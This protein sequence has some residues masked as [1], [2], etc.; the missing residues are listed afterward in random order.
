VGASSTCTSQRVQVT[1]LTRDRLLLF[2][3]SGLR[4]R[5]HTPRWRRRNVFGLRRCFAY[6]CSR[7]APPDHIPYTRTHPRTKPKNVTSSEEL[8]HA[9]PCDWQRNL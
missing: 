2:E 3:G 8:R 7:R 5:A 6:S 4:G 9:N 1:P